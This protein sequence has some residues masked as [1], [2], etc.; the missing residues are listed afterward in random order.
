VTNAKPP[1]PPRRRARRALLGVL[2]L[3][4]IVAVAHTAAW[5]WATGAL[6]VGMSD[7]MTQRRAEG[8]TISH[9]P[10]VRGGWPFAARISLAQ[11]RIETPARAHEAGILHHAA[12][13]VLQV[14][15]PRPGHLQVLLEGPQRLQLGGTVVPFEARRFAMAVP[16]AAGPAPPLELEI[17][18]L[19]ALLPGGPV[20]L[21]AAR[22]VLRPG[23]GPAPAAG[24]GGSAAPAAGPGPGAPR[25]G[26]AEPSVTLTLQAEGLVPPASPLTDALGR[27]IDAVSAEAILV[28]APPLRGPPAMMAAAWRDAGGVFE[29]PALALRWGP[30]LGDAQASVTLDRALQPRGNGRLRLAGAPAAVDALARAGLVDGAAARSV[31]AVLALMSRTPPEGG[32]PRVELPLAL[33][34]GTV[35]AARVP[36]LRVAPIAWSGSRAW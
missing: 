4:G 33:A 2:V 19:E 32:P 27:E 15:A 24:Q 23:S 29:I 22:M 1:R 36:L 20:R 35:S 34:D 8:W 16:F 12:R 10:L 5:T 9:Q 3:A 31:Q 25:P 7:W 11:T 17:A 14:E 26:E 18:A 13:L 30:L 21:R 6:A 28:G